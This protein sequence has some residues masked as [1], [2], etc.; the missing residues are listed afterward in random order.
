VDKTTLVPTRSW[1]RTEEHK[2][3]SELSEIDY[4]PNWR[5][6]DREF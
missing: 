2:L 6:S 4:A 5:S 1:Q 3:R